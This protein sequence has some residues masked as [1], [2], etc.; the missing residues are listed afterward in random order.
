MPEVENP[1]DD[2]QT[3]ILIYIGNILQPIVGQ[4]SKIVEGVKT[5]VSNTNKLVFN[6]TNPELD[7]I[8]GE[9]AA[10][11]DGIIGNGIDTRIPTDFEWGNFRHFLDIFFIF[12][13]FIVILI[14]IILKFLQIVFVGIPNIAAN[15]DLFAQYPNI[16]EGVN[17]VKNL[18]VGGLAITVHQAFEFVF[19]IFFYIFIIKQIRKMYNAHVYEESAENPRIAQDMKMDYYENIK[20]KRWSDNK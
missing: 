9:P 2:E 5:I 14:L 15:T 20:N 6:T 16:L 13:Y 11:G 1:D 19:L 12:I 4:L 18:Q 7:P 10:A 17:Y 3:G 8:T